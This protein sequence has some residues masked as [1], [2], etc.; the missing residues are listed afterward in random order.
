[1]FNGRNVLTN[2]P[3]DLTRVVNFLNEKAAQGEFFFSNSLSYWEDNV[4]VIDS[5]GLNFGGRLYFAV[6]LAYLA[7]LNDGNISFPDG[8]KER[9]WALSLIMLAEYAEWAPSFIK[10]VMASFP[11]RADGVETLMNNAAH[12]YGRKNYVNGL[13]LMKLLPKYQDSIKAGLMEVD[14]ERYCADFP[15]QDNYDEY[16]NVFAKATRMKEED[17]GKAFDIAIEFPSFT[18][19]IAMVF[20]LTAHSHLDDK[21]KRICENRIRELLS[22]GNTAQYVNPV[23][24]WAFLLKKSTPFMEESII[25]LIKG[26]GK[27]N[28]SLLI[29]VDNALAYN[30]DDAEFLVRL[31]FEIAESLDPTDIWKLNHCLQNLSEKRKVFLDLVLSFVIH[32]KGMYRIA[33][34]RLWDQFHLENSDFNFAELEEPLQ[35][36]FIISLLQDY[37]NPDIRLPK[38]LPLLK[39]DSQRVRNTLMTFLSSYI[40]DYMGHVSK[41]IDSLGIECEEATI[42]KK[43]ID[44]RGEAIKLRRELKE[45]SPSYTDE[46]VFREAVR[47][48]REHLKEEMKETEGRYKPAWTDLLPT[49]VLAR[50][51]GWRESDGTNRHLSVTSFS[52]PTRIMAESMSLKERDEWFN[53]LLKDWD[54]TTGNH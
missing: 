28:S 7:N 17:Y 1:M 11:C 18:S 49:V 14:F 34:R 13:A 23:S 43:Y 48:Q 15:P 21:K 38:I 42:I 22:L 3:G 30:H 46:K 32:P 31:I 5:L 9:R 6:S 41:A 51:G 47:Q 12:T 54:D 52:V 2:F 40:D 44:D 8:V 36:L 4:S 39:T 10:N 24:N 53:Q 50:G 19:A 29:A 45:L 16:A 20:F 37:G 26:L 33:G 35:C 27:E 25:S